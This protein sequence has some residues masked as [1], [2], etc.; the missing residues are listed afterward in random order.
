MD[1]EQTFI[2]VQERFSQM[3]TPKVRAV[4]EYLYL[5]IAITL[6]C[7]LVVMHANFVQ[8]VFDSAFPL[9]LSVLRYNI[10]ILLIISL[11]LKGRGGE[12]GDCFVTQASKLKSFGW[13]ILILFY[14]KP[15][16][17]SELSGVVTADAQL[18]QIKVY[19]AFHSLNARESLVQYL[20]L[21]FNKYYKNAVKW[22]KRISFVWRSFQKFWN[23]AGIHLNLDIPKWMHILH[24]D[25]LSSNAVQWLEKRSKAFEPTYLYTMEKGYFLLPESAKSRHNIHTM[26]ISIS[27]RHSCFG[28][29]WQQLLINRFVGYDTILMNSLLSSP[30]QGYLYNFQTKE[31]YNLSYAQEPPEGPARFGDY[32]V[33][34]CGVLMMSL[35][36]FF[37]TTMSVSFTLRETQTRMLKFTVQLQHHAR[38][39]LPTFQLIFVHV[40]ESL[41]FVPIMIGILFFLFEFYDDQLLAFMV[42]I[43]VWLCELFTLISVRTPISMKFFPRF[44]LLYFLVFHIYFFSYA[45][46][47]SYLALSTTAAFMQHLILYFWNRFEVTLNGLFLVSSLKFIEPRLGGWISSGTCLYRSNLHITILVTRRRN[48]AVELHLKG[49]N[50]VSFGEP[51]EGCIVEDDKEFNMEGL[52]MELP[53]APFHRSRRLCQQGSIQS[54]NELCLIWTLGEEVSQGRVSSNS[55]TRNGAH[56]QLDISQTPYMQKLKRL[57]TWEWDVLLLALFK[58]LLAVS[59]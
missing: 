25:K 45:F 40:I 52:A 19:V 35:F 14:V 4:L 48:G 58:T 34:K 33:I 29:R 53:D 16:C 27:A 15:G 13:L 59:F 12:D 43:L 2:R 17:S 41:V 22:Y 11:F 56:K 42:L 28:N 55:K 36:V 32:L 9:S 1:P 23:I 51:F 30:G 57:I 44:F 5:F 20:Y 38:H 8:Q 18:I 46:G 31:F 26:N 7:I 10:G 47:F 37:T 54:P 24:L 39:R 21:P 6:F 50:G 49:S 3:L